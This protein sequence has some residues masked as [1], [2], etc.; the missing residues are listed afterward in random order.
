VLRLVEHQ[1]VNFKLCW[2]QLA[3]IIVDRA[4]AAEEEAN[5]CEVE[6]DVRA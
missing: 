6:R 3:S 2:S 4:N 1:P 5:R